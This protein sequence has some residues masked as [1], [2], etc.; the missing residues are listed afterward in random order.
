[1]LHLVVKCPLDRVRRRAAYP[2]ATPTNEWYSTDAGF[3][4]KLGIRALEFSEDPVYMGLEAS[5]SVDRSNISRHRCKS[6]Q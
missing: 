4:L 2:A 1:M 3:R 6:L 5:S